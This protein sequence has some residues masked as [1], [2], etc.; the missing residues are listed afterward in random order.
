MIRRLF[1][2]FVFTLLLSSYWTQKSD[3]LLWKITGNGLKA[4][5]YLYGTVHL[6]DDRVFAFDSTVYEKI[7][8][9]EALSG[10]L[11]MTGKISM[12]DP[13][14]IFMQDTMLV[15]LYE[16][17]AEYEIVRKY[18]VKKLGIF[19]MATDSM[20]PVYTMSLISMMDTKIDQSIPLDMYFQ[21]YASKQG[22]KV[23]GIETIDEQQAALDAIPLK[24]Q[25]SLLLESIQMEDSISEENFTETMV[26]YYLNQDLTR[27]DS[28]IN[29]ASSS[30]TFEK[31][32]IQERNVLMA[33]RIDTLIRKQPT[34]NTL[35]AGH[36]KG[37]NGVI[38]LLRAK[39]YKLEPIPFSFIEK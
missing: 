9:C 36:L 39:G 4:P 15:D 28:L 35:G 1:W 16:N 27:L 19:V 32:I 21:Q 2:L 18:L 31:K 11:L 10:E 3:S 12:P 30:G 14:D 33:D 23:Y 26:K 5:S 13:K 38:E 37:E 29:H 17:T 7:N 8:T 6:M 20:K 24:E 34:F 25:A 22:K